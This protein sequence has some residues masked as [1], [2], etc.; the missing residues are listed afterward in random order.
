GA[1]TFEILRQARGEFSVAAVAA[2]RDAERLAA[3][4]R[5]FQARLAVIADP[6]RYAEPKDALAGSG[7]EAAADKEGL[8]AAAE[9]QADVVVAGIMGA[10]G[11]EPT[12]AALQPGRRIAIANKE[13]LVCAGELF[14]QRVRET[15]ATILPVDSEHNAV[16]QA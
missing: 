15:G 6:S 16:L 8:I 14:M 13:C 2:G 10:A 4:A 11:L 3:L 7:I 12:L 9:M 1:S 5:E